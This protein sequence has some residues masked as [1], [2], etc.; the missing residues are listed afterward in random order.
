MK[1][2][3]VCSLFLFRLI[4]KT[5]KDNNCLDRVIGFFASKNR[6]CNSCEAEQRKGCLN[7]G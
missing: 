7:N 3:N 2:A 4:I 1:A 6:N 5:Q